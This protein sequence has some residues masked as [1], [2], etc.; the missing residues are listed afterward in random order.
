[1][2]AK[3]EELEHRLR[4]QFT[5]IHHQTVD[6]FVETIER[7]VVG[8]ISAIENSLVEQ[9]HSIVSL[10]E[11]SLRTDDNLQRLLEAVEKLCG[12]AEIQAQIVM[13]PPPPSPEPQPI[14]KHSL[15]EPPKQP[16]TFETHYREA[17]HRQTGETG[18]AERQ[19][20]WAVAGGGLNAS[21]PGRSFRTVGVALVGLAFIGFRMLR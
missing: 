15:P 3:I 17:L 1:M 18:E 9:A 14:E 12:R 4:G 8:R 11:K 16:E 6:T 2:N 19:P 21:M 13:P 7:R 5:E 10:R 20:E